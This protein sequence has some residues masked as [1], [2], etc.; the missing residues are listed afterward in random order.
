MNIAI[1]VLQGLLATLFVAVGVGKLTQPKEKLAE[2]MG[3]VENFSP[4]TIKLIGLLEVLAALGLI[5]P[6][7]TGVAP[8]LTPLAAAGLGVVM[9][10]AI[11]VHRRRRENTEILVNAVL[12]LLAAALAWSRFGPYSF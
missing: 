1:W 9:V 12:L 6:P 7:L 4:S 5:L 2:R 3:W 10:G 11:V 8:V